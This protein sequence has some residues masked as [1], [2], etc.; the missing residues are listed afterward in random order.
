MSPYGFGT[1]SAETRALQQALAGLGLFA[2][3]IDGIFGGTL[4][5][6]NARTSSA[7]A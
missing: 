6:I 2:G 4:I 1:R 3:Q 5:Y 7:S